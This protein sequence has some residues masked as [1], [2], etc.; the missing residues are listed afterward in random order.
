MD[1]NFAPTAIVLQGLSFS[2]VRDVEERNPLLFLYVADVQ[3]T[4]LFSTASSEQTDQ[5]GP[6]PLRMLS[7]LFEKFFRRKHGKKFF[8][9]VIPIALDLSLRT[10]HTWCKPVGRIEVLGNK[11]L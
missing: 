5:H 7:T 10:F 9:G 8:I 2:A 4:R 1:R 6:I 11:P 3:L